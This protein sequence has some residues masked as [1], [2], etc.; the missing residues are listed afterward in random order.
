MTD[1]PIKFISHLE[2]Y[3]N[4]LWNFHFKVPANVVKTL[5][6]DKVK[7]FLCQIN[8]GTPFHAALLPAGEEIYFIKVNKELRSQHRITINDSLSITLTKDESQYGIPLPA[9]IEELLLLDPEGNQHFQNLSP[10]KQRS[11]LYLVGKLKSK[12][13]RYE[14]SF[15]ILEHLKEYK[16]VLDFKILNQDFKDKKGYV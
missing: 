12:D 3:S 1:W 4:S 2:K 16:G 8:Q 5:R 10:G 6:K 13:K 7:R 15:I 11:L 9:E 14:K